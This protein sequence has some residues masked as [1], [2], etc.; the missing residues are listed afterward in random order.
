M[1]AR[2]LAV[3]TSIAAFVFSLNPA[4]SVAPRPICRSC[5]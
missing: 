1:L 5:A 4:S 3:L 2:R